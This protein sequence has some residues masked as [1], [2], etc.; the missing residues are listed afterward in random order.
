M[1]SAIL[2]LLGAF[3]LS[4]LGLFAFIWSL[5]KGLLVENPRGAG[6]IFARGE[7]GQVDDPALADPALRQLQD[8]STAREGAPAGADAGE[9]HDRIDADRSSAFPVFMFIAFACLWLLVG[10]AAGLTASIKLHAPDWLTGDAWLGFGR[11]RAVHTNAVFYGWVSNA[12]IAVILWLLPRLLRTRLAGAGWA[13]LG[14][15]LLNAG[16]AAG[17]GAIASGW[18]DGMEFLEIPW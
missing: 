1:D 9:L 10:S 6:V 15:S 18:S 2:S 17:I 12:C 5:R 16:V 13:M 3:L 11:L 14:G 7:I 8:V 4:I